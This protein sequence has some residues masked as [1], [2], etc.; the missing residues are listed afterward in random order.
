MS[1]PRTLTHDER[2]A[3]EAAFENR[4]FNPNWSHAAQIVYDGLS[5][6]LGHPPD[7]TP[8]ASSPHADGPGLKTT[9]APY[10]GPSLQSW[11]VSHD[12][13]T[14]LCFFPARM[15]LTS[16][17]RY[18]S[19]VLKRTPFTLASVSGGMLTYVGEAT[20]IKE[21]SFNVDHE[22]TI[23]ERSQRDPRT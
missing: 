1:H 9:P 23:I 3:A 6:Q 14:S 15:P 19:A 13:T 20:F 7:A 2:K 8:P 10:H 22:G 12:N 16:I 17:V 5:R 4:P 11:A 21:R 18:L